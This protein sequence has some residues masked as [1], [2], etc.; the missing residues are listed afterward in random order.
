MIFEE[1][2]SSFY[3]L[4]NLDLVLR[5]NQDQIREIVTIKNHFEV[6]IDFLNFKSELL[7]QMN[8]INQENHQTTHFY[9]HCSFINLDTA[10]PEEKNQF[11]FE[12]LATIVFI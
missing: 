10:T 6:I 4:E 7:G 9:S 8:T 3:L 1:E 12:G 2:K 11:L 5:S